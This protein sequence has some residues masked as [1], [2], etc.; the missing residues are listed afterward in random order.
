MDSLKKETGIRIRS[1]RKL[2][3]MTQEQ[4]AEKLGVSVKHI[5]TVERGLSMLSVPHLIGICDILDCDLDYLLRGRTREPI[6]AFL[7][8]S[9]CEIVSSGNEDEARLFNVYLLIYKELRGK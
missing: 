9:V 7:P 8:N 1:L 3:G 5:S 6:S 4:L 2:N